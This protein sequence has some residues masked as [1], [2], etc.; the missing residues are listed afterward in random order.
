MSQTIRNGQI[1]RI[2]IQTGEKLAAVAVTGSYSVTVLAGVGVGTSLAT[3]VTGG[4]YG[5]YAYPLV[6]QVSASAASEIDYDVGVS[7][8][9]ESD[10]FAK[11]ATDPL[12][13]GVV[14]LTGPDG[15]L[16]ELFYS[17]QNITYSEGKVASFE[18]AG[19]I[20]T[21]GY[22]VDGK[23]ST[24]TSATGITRTAGYDS[25]GNIISFI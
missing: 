3:S 14:G 24:V 10:T 7:T 15:G 12:T 23:I 17:I 16:V 20:W 4:T 22:A 8:N 21:V 13:G 19:V 1:I 18:S 6:V 25:N 11:I 2:S 9:I 5:P